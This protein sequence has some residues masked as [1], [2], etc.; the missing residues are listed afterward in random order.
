MQDTYKDHKEQNK[1]YFF[2]GI[3]S[4]FVPQIWECVKKYW[5]YGKKLK[6][7]ILDEQQYRMK[8][9]PVISTVKIKKNGSTKLINIDYFDMIIVTFTFLTSLTSLS[10]FFPFFLSLSVFFILIYT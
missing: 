8:E 3:F 7:T 9:N 1:R 5:N 4:R 6:S 10:V 2:I